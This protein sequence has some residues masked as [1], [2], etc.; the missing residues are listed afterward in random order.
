MADTCPTCT[1]NNRGQLIYPCNGI[2]TADDWHDATLEAPAAPT[3]D[4][5]GLALERL[6]E[7]LANSAWNLTTHDQQE[8]WLTALD[9]LTAALTDRTAAIAAAREAGREEQRALDAEAHGEV[10]R[11][12]AVDGELGMAEFRLNAAQ[13]VLREFVRGNP[14]A[15]EMGEVLLEV[16]RGAKFAALVTQPTTSEEA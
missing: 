9:T 8:A 1:S 5:V 13:N 12:E 6:R 11:L 3:D 7:S 16:Q 4:A 2:G 10:A 14:D 15:Q